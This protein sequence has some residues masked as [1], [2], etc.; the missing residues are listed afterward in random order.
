M[1]NLEVFYLAWMVTGAAVYLSNMKT[2]WE[3]ANKL[4]HES[5]LMSVSPTLVG[6]VVALGLVLSFATVMF[7]WPWNLYTRAKKGTAE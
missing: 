4:A 2:R 3:G 5:P 1:S 7:T 6:L